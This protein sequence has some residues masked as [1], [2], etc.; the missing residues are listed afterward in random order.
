MFSDLWGSVLT[1]VYSWHA[2]F[3]WFAI[4]PLLYLAL[5]AYVVASSPL[6]NSKITQMELAY[7]KANTIQP[8][9]QGKLK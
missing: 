3:Y 2:A 8:E 6:S 1:K 4:F 7:L 5:W 9:G